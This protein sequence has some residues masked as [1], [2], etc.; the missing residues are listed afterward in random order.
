MQFS[1]ARRLSSASTVYHGAS[2][3]SVCSEHL[4]LGRE[5]STQRVARLEVHRA[6][7]PAPQRILRALL[8]A[9]LLLGVAD[10][11]PVLEQDDPVAHEHALELRARAQE[12]AVLLVGAEAHHVLDAGAVVPGAV[13]QHDLAG[14]RQVGD[15]A[16]EVPLRPLALG[17]RAERDDR[18]RR[19]GSA[20]RGCA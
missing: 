9:P 20:A 10:R 13:E 3:V 2:G 7:L 14:R 16:L 6:Q 18:A 17:R 12:L 4:V 1:R 19:A 11:E 15:V 8:E 5:N